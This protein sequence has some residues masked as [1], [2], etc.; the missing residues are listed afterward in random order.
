VPLLGIDA[1][2]HCSS[3]MT[4]RMSAHAPRTIRFNESKP[5]WQFTRCASA[6]T[7][8]EPRGDRILNDLSVA[9]DLPSR[10]ATSAQVIPRHRGQ[11]TR[12][13]T[14]GVAARALLGI[15]QEG[16]G[17][18]VVHRRSVV[19]G[20]RHWC[21]VLV[22]NWLRHLPLSRSTVKCTKGARPDRSGSKNPS[23]ALRDI[24]VAPGCRT[25]C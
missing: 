16:S 21:G 4:A 8:W 13:F 20:L 19:L 2:T 14:R 11:E 9:R 25:V 22:R 12:C 6:C 10:C 1:M 23:C 3:R 5:L 15:G 17:S 24:T 7:R 18:V